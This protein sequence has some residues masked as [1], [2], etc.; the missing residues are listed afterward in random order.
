MAPD[1]N[2]QETQQETGTLASRRGNN[3]KSDLSG[4]NFTAKQWGSKRTN[5]SRPSWFTWW[6]VTSRPRRLMK[7]SSIK[8]SKRRDLQ[9]KWLHRETTIYTLLL[10]IQSFFGQSKRMKNWEFLTL[11]ERWILTCRQV[12]NT[13]VCT[14]NQIFLLRKSYQNMGFLRRKSVLWINE[15]EI[16]SLCSFLKCQTLTKKVKRCK[17]EELFVQN[18]SKTCLVALILVLPRLLDNVDSKVEYRFPLSLKLQ[19]N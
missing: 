1:T 7:T 4:N 10:L 16:A 5:H 11:R 13:N 19:C 15:F 9:L 8:Q 14:R 2:N 12:L 18:F 6:R 3:F 17:L